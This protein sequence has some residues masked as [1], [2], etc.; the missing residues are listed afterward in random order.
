MHTLYTVL[1]AN[2]RTRYRRVTSELCFR[3]TVDDLH[4]VTIPSTK[5]R[6]GRVSERRRDVICIRR[7]IKYYRV[8]HACPPGL[9]TDNSCVG[10]CVLYPKN[11]SVE[12]HKRA[13]YPLMK[14][15][16]KF[17]YFKYAR[18]QW[19]KNVFIVRVLFLPCRS[20]P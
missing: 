16:E 1:V 8:K 18:V 9:D 11:V 7:S 15:F 17:E 10:V 13:R 6:Y 5:Y 12:K 2:G 20:P 14:R 4:F 3:A 19:P